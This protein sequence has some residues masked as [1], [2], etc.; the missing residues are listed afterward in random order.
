MLEPSFSPSANQHRHNILR[1]DVPA[2]V[3]GAVP[4][5]SAND[6]ST[7]ARHSAD[8]F[9]VCSVVSKAL[10]LGRPVQRFE[11]GKTGPVHAGPTQSGFEG[12]LARAR[13]RSGLPH[14]THFG[15]QGSRLVWSPSF[16]RPVRS[17]CPRPCVT[18][19]SQPIVRRASP[20]LWCSSSVR[21]L[22]SGRTRLPERGAPK[23]LVGVPALDEHRIKITFPRSIQRGADAPA[24]LPSRARWFPQGDAATSATKRVARASALLGKPM[25]GFHDYAP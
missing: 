19:S 22:L 24:N 9:S 15:H 8:S 2:R 6:P 16:G 20:G 5:R 23:S 14:L 18:G 10:N 21:K 13:A 7:D 11:F 25:K 17:L 1:R 3:R 4:G 12:S